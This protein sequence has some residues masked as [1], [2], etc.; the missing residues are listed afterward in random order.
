MFDECAPIE[1]YRDSLR[2]IREF[3]DQFDLVLRNHGNYRS[4]KAI[5]E[6]NIELCGQILERKDAAIPTEFHEVAGLMARPELH[7][8][9]EGNIVYS[10]ENLFRKNT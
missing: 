2:H 10:P 5:L 3:S 8:G 7:P 1:T 4:A 6:D 9:K